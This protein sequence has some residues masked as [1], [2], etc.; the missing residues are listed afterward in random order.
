MSLLWK[1]GDGKDVLRE[2]I[3]GNGDLSTVFDLSDITTHF[4]SIRTAKNEIQEHKNTFNS[5]ATNYNAYNTIKSFLEKKID[6]TDDT[7]FIDS[8]T[9]PTEISLNNIIDLLNT[10]IGSTKDEKY[11]KQTGDKTFICTEDNPGSTTTPPNNNLLHPW[12]CEPIYR[13]WIKNLDNTDTTGIKNYAEITSD[14][15][16]VLKYASNEKT[17][18]D[19]NYQSYY[20]VLTDLKSD[21]SSYL[22]TF[23]DVLDFFDEVT[24]NIIDIIEDGIGNSNDTFSFLNGHFIKTNL[25]IVLKYLKYSL[26]EDIYTVG[27]CLVIVGFSLIFSISSTIL[28]IVIINIDLEKNK[29][30]SQDTEVP[31]YPVTNDGRVI[32]FKYD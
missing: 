12:F 22:R 3:V 21:Y 19:G 13:E 7:N 25:K 18:D 5:L 2:S 10:K 1:L 24:G 15:I 11:N 6:F 32:Q 23:L 26:G 17:P 31:N 4:N 8:S 14:A 9:T 16:T 20:D 29:K 28:L 30:L 27:I